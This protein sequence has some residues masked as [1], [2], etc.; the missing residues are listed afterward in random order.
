M[1]IKRL[2]RGLFEET[3]VVVHLELALDLVDGIEHNADHDEHRSAAEGLDERV[4]G[5][6][7]HNRGN[8]G[9]EARKTA[10]GSVIL[11]RAFL[12]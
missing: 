12:M 4:V 6:R 10:L 1:F 9:D 3:V 7:E 8:D 11:L 5:E 2:L